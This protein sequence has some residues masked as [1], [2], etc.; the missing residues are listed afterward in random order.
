M[1]PRPQPPS[2]LSHIALTPTP[3]SHSKPPQSITFSLPVMNAARHAVVAMVGEGKAEAVHT[4]LLEDKGPGGFPAQQASWR[5]F[6]CCV[7]TRGGVEYARTS[8]T[9][10]FLSQCVAVATL[11]CCAPPVGAR[12]ASAASRWAAFP[13]R[14]LIVFSGSM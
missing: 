6:R 10:R 7:R 13:S 12:R 14:L 11:L 2:A 4:A 8:A 5:V 1:L 9:C 3:R